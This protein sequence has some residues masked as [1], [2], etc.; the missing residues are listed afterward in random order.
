MKPS[1]NPSALLYLPGITGGLSNF[2]KS[3]CLETQRSTH[4]LGINS[5]VYRRREVGV[6][7]DIE[8]G[9]GISSRRVYGRS[10]GSMEVS[11]TVGV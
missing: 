4:L 11:P 2:G 9:D 8:Q 7:R 1:P 6:N 3:G 10:H 5:L